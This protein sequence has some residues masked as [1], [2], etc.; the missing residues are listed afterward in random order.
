[1][2][3]FRKK[4][5][6]EQWRKELDRI[7]Y[8]FPVFQEHLEEFGSYLYKL[9]V[10]K[11]VVVEMHSETY[12][13]IGCLRYDKEISYKFSVNIASQIRRKYARF[14]EF[15]DVSARKDAIYKNLRK[16]NNLRKKEENYWTKLS[17]K[18]FEEAVLNLYNSLGYE[19]KKTQYVADG[20]IDGKLEKDGKL[21]LIQCKR[22]KKP[23]GVQVIRDMYGT[24]IHNEADEGW[25]ISTSGFSKSATQ[26]TTGKAIKLVNLSELVELSNVAYPEKFYIGGENIDNLESALNAELVSIYEEIIENHGWHNF[27]MEDWRFDVELLRKLIKKSEK[28]A[29]GNASL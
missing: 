19:T 23:V 16:V 29:R 6:R 22:L 10:S 28:S 5:N 12:H 25:I 17:P 7:K 24:L 20:G 21:I 14:L 18:L 2:V 1:V 15:K 8:D 11:T 13:I 26:W 9:E 27:S 4:A 3:L